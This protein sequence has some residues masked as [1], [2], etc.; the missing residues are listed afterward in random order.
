[1]AELDFIEAIKQRQRTMPN[2]TVGIGDD[3]AIIEQGHTKGWS[4]ATD[5]LLEG[6]HFDSHVHHPADIGRKALAVNLS[7]IAAMGS[8]PRYALV[9]LAIPVGYGQDR[10]NLLWSGLQ[11]L[12]DSFGVVVIG[13][14]TNSWQD[15]LAI[16]VTVIGE[17]H[18]QGYILRSGAR[19]GDELFVTGALGGSMVADHHLKFTPRVNEAQQLL[20]QVLPSAMIDLSDGLATELRHICKSSRVGANI[21]AQ[22]IPISNR[23]SSKLSHEIRLRH[24][25]TDGEDFELLFSV[26][27]DDA[28]RVQ[29]LPFTCYHIGTI[30]SGSALTIDG[31]PLAGHGFEHSF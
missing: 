7:D 24:A 22:S 10:V 29:T 26:R 5:M 27:S 12:A 30:T 25:L 4:V 3:A 19:S 28:S 21:R 6:R 20:A 9:S 31:I 2:G 18:P 1:M 11:T 23:L 16:N 17:P 8:I 13:G 15:G 14:D